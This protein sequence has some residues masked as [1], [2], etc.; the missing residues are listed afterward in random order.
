MQAT[1]SV[2]GRAEQPRPSQ[3]EAV[4]PEQA[5]E[6]VSYSPTMG[7]KTPAQSKQEGRIEEE[8]SQRRDQMST[9]HMHQELRDKDHS[10]TGVQTLTY[11]VQKAGDEEHPN[12]GGMSER[13]CYFPYAKIY[14]NKLS[15]NFSFVV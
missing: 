13:F 15:M 8:H 12:K 2:L 10:Q 6:Q 4:L 1:Y 11:S 7:N 14:T 5:T 3:I 9:T